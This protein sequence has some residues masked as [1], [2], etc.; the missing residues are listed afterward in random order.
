MIKNETAV[1]EFIETF[2]VP[3]PIRYYDDLTHD[4][5]QVYFKWLPN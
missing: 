2:D 3:L 4:D 1:D 5:K